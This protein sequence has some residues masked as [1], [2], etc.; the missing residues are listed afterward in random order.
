MVDLNVPLQ[1]VWSRIL[2]L[3]IGTEGA[4]I[5]GRIVDEPMSNQLA[6]SFKSFSVDS[7]SAAFHRTEIRA[8]Q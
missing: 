4:L 7:S 2:T 1:I 8:V 3:L 5:T 6:F